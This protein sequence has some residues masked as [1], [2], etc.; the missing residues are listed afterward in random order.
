MKQNRIKK[1][2]MKKKEKEREEVLEVFEIL[3]KVE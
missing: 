3:Y 1:G 2:I